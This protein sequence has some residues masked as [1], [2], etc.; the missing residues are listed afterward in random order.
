M[1]NRNRLAPVSLTGEHPVT[2]FEIDLCMTFSHFFEFFNNFL[3]S[4]INRKSVKIIGIDKNTR[5]TVCKS[6]FLNIFS[7]LYN[8]DNRQIKFFC[9]IPVTSIVCRNC[10]NCTCTVRYQYIV[11]YKYRNLCII[12][13]VNS[14]NTFN[15]N[16]C[17]I[18]CNFRSLKI[19]FL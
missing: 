19:G 7:A 10:H 11:R 2:Q 4:V 13:R 14:L 3:F 18:F 8:F 5:C 16:A 9:K 15:F 6:S 1:Y 12:N 17:F